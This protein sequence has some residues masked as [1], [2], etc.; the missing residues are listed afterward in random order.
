MSRVLVLT[1]QYY[2]F[3]NSLELTLEF[4]HFFPSLKIN[5]SLVA[6][7]NAQGSKNLS[8]KN[9]AWFEAILLMLV[10][11]LTVLSEYI[12]L[13]A[14]TLCALAKFFLIL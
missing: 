13:V 7:E 3:L 8:E 10:E 14:D 4:L 2:S 11:V 12:V 5:C 1:L 9:Q 6:P